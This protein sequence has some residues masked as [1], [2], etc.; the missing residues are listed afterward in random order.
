MKRLIT[1]SLFT[2]SLLF[3]NEIISTKTPVLEHLFVDSKLWDTAKSNIV[4]LYPQTTLN[5]NDKNAKE[6]LKNST[7]KGVEVRVLYNNSKVA[8]KFRWSDETQNIYR[9]DSTDSYADGIAVEFPLKFDD[10]KNLPYIG[11]GDSNREVLIFLT[12][13]YDGVYE[14]NANIDYQISPNNKP[15]FGDELTNYKNEVQRLAK[16]YTKAFIAKGFKT[17][18]EIKDKEPFEFKMSY[19]DGFW[20]ALLVKDLKDSY[21]NLDVDTFPISIAIWDGNTLNRDGNKKISKWIPLTLKAK[22][23]K[24]VQILNYE[25]KGNLENGKKLVEQNCFA[26]HSYGSMD[27]QMPYMAPNLSNIGGY[28]NASY[29]IESIKEPNKAIILG[30]NKNAHKNTHWYS[31]E[32]GKEVSAMPSYSHLKDSEI[33]DI[34]TYLQTLKAEVKK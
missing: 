20:E 11:M 30:Y 3:A 13:A 26:C 17:T 12:K 23:E 2:T 33:I 32:N 15:V 29:L 4:T 5:L 24:Y 31:I 21:V 6:L 19:K 27:N 10:P 25:Y 34:V 1:L 7:A 28:G 16:N 9:A 8:F 18:T 22:N 14:P